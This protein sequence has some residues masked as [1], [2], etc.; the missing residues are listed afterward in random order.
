MNACR[1]V[2]PG[3]HA[4]TD[5]LGGWC[6]SNAG[7]VTDGD[8]AL[9]VDTLATERRARTFAAEVD[10]LCPGP[11]RIVVNTHFHGD[12]TFGNHVFAPHAVFVGH[13][14]LGG[15]MN[16]AGLA[17]VGLWPSVEWGDVRIIPPTVTFA[18]RMTLHIGRIRTELIHPGPA[19]TTADTLVWLPESRVLFAGDVVMSGTTPFVL[20]GSVRGIHATLRM[21]TAMAPDVIVAGH[22]PVAGPEVIDRNIEYL[23]WI[24]R[25]AA[26]GRTVGWTPLRTALEYGPGDFADLLDG[27]RIVGNLHRAYAELDGA[28]D[29]TPLDVQ[30]IFSEIVEYN[31]GTVPVCLA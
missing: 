9:V 5:A 10:V 30:S 26:R 8:T 24:Q 3:V 17:L 29:G 12:H 1:E 22:G 28:A 21:V 2:A 13:E 7:V 23:E 4:Y 6:V 19:H 25:I 31:G 16:E 11:R 20:M 18:D 27:E 15:E 14:R